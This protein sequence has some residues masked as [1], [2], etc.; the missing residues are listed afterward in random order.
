VNVGR[1]KLSVNK[2]FFMENGFT[3][4]TECSLLPD[5]WDVFSEMIYF[6]IA[7]LNM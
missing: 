4:R 5:V 1:N 2:L 6:Y 3:Q 7:I